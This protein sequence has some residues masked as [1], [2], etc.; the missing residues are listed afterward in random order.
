MFGKQTWN[1]VSDL[2][3]CAGAGCN[4]LPQ[5]RHAAHNDGNGK[6]GS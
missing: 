5:E 2:C 1:F 3:L 6:D 4:G